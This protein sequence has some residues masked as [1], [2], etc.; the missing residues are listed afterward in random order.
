[1]KFTQSLKFSLAAAFLLVFALVLARCSSGG[2]AA[3]TSTVDSAA[4]LAN[5][6]TIAL[7]PAG[8][9]ADTSVSVRGSG[10]PAVKMVLVKLADVQGHSPVLAAAM[11]DAGG[12]FAAKFTYPA[13][14]RW[15]QPG[16]QTVIVQTE[17]NQVEVGASFLVT[18]PEGAVTPAATPSAM[19]TA[20]VSATVTAAVS[21]TAAAAA[22]PTLTA[23]PVPTAT[24]AL[25]AGALAVT[26]LATATATAAPSATATAVPS[27]TPTA[28]PTSGALAV[29]AD[30][31]STVEL[32]NGFR[33]R[34]L[35]AD[36][37]ADGSSIWRYSV[38]KL[39]GAKKLQVLGLELP[40]CVEIL[41]ASPAEW[42][43]V[44]AGGE[45]EL[46]GIS[47][48]VK[49]NSFQAGEF[50]VTVR[51]RVAA[52]AV[53]VAAKAAKIEAGVIAGPQCR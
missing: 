36:Q 5:A 41:D 39:A 24:I 4:V 34:F 45:G 30:L 40:G 26:P 42:E 1:M 51:G 18:L 23:T 6:P 50:A 3:P 19:V 32:G 11:T 13:G 10:W 48:K 33:V 2:A 29:P 35:G 49:G 22:A 25:N 15:L 17:D 12:Q 8:G 7:S 53:H 16:V 31:P 20:A 47:W 43:V 28:T 44:P 14:E 21:P 52:G 38:E 9:Y 46:G 27:A 37:G